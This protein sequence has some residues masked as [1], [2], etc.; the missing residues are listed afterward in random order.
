VGQYANFS[1]YL[2][3]NAS[4]AQAT[5]DDVF[6]QYLVQ[7]SNNMISTA[8]PITEKDSNGISQTHFAWTTGFPSGDPALDA[9]EENSLYISTAQIARAAAV[10]ASVQKWRTQFASEIQRWVQTVEGEL[11]PDIPT[12]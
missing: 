8:G 1:I 5:L 4:A 9:Y 12:A 10:L 11:F 7:Y 6:A 3:G 2:A